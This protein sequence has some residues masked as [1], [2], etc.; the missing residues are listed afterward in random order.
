[1]NKKRSNIEITK[2]YMRSTINTSVLNNKKKQYKQ[3]KECVLCV[4]KDH[5]KFVCPTLKCYRTPLL[6]KT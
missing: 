4:S 1:M 5:G 6:D 3:I 2:N